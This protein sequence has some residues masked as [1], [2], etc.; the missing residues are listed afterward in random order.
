MSPNIY[1]SS[2]DLEE[3][4]RQQ[5][6][7][8]ISELR[9]KLSSL[10]K[11]QQNCIW[12]WTDEKDSLACPVLTRNPKTTDE[13][14]AKRFCKICPR[15]LAVAGSKRIT[16]EKINTIVHSSPRGQ[17]VN[18]GFHFTERDWDA[19]FSQLVTAD[20]TNSKYICNT[21]RASFRI[22]GDTRSHVMSTHGNQYN[23]AINYHLQNRNKPQYG[24][25]V[26]HGT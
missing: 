18:A 24:D 15:Y 19:V 10:E 3:I 7:K 6:V 1:L 13:E 23:Q 2:K 21:C 12:S 11:S 20:F 26:G 22:L 4:F 9:E 8:N 25:Y 14:L 17:E 5:N 16:I